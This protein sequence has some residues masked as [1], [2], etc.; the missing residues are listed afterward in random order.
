MVCVGTNRGTR[1]RLSSRQAE[2]DIQQDQCV[3]NDMVEVGNE[4]CIAHGENPNCIAKTVIVALQLPLGRAE[5]REI[6]VAEEFHDEP[7]AQNAQQDPF[8]HRQ[9]INRAAA[10]R[11][12]GRAWQTQRF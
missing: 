2:N 4:P 5:D 7:E 12:K 8:S 9:E 6:P 3:L 1:R 11:C 10:P